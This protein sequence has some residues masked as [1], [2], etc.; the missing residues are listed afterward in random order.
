MIALLNPVVVTA[1]RTN[2]KVTTAEVISVR[3]AGV[4]K[5]GT[6]LMIVT[7]EGMHVVQVTI[8]RCFRVR[9]I[10]SFGNCPQ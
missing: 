1:W 8:V 2:I 7:D 3:G 4:G 6:P 9:H 5:L 10:Q